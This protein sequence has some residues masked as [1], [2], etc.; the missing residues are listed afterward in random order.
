[1]TML[2]RIQ[3]YCLAKSGVTYYEFKSFGEQ[4]ISFNVLGM[5]PTFVWEIAVNENPVRVVIKCFDSVLQ[6]LPENAVQ[7]SKS[8]QWGGSNWRWVDVWLDGTLSEEVL[9][10][11]LDEGYQ[12]A[13]AELDQ[14]DLNLINIIESDLIPREALNI[15]IE[16]NDLAYRRE[17][18]ELL[19]DTAILLHTRPVEEETIQIGQS[20]MGGSPD[21]PEDWAYPLFD[22]IALPFLAQVNLAEIPPAMR[23]P[24]L[25]S[26]GILYFFSHFGWEE[27][28]E[29]VPHWETRHKETGFSQVLYYN[30]ELTKLKRWKHP[31][32]DIAFKAASIEFS[33]VMSIP[34]GGD[35]YCRD[36][37]FSNYDWLEE[38]FERFDDL[39]FDFSYVLHQ[40]ELSS[41]HQLLGY[42]DP[43]H[44]AVTTSSTQLLFETITDDENMGRIPGNGG[45][46]YFTIPHA[47]LDEKNFSNVHTDFHFD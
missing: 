23:K 18:I 44:D 6:T 32:I 43:V 45:I 22:G 17:D 38:E 26:T 39:Y 9:F 42:A 14:T 2:E 29:H 33:A 20:K 16:S 46:I 47:D 21:L 34:R 13:L 10:Q 19:L 11:L 25:P 1:M 8:I 30:G 28:H 5:T 27:P 24:W 7:I 4:R 36:P 15:L 31:E 35:L 12:L 40:K 41:G 37:I 3:A